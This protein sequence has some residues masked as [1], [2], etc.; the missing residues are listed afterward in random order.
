M[1]SEDIF[2]CFVILSSSAETRG[3][4]PGEMCE[5]IPA[6]AHLEWELIL[7]RVH[8]LVLWWQRNQEVCNY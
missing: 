8:Y 1:T 3:V 7:N 6:D 5:D 4:S 2:C